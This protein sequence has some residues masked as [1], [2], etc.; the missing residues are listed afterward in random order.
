MSGIDVEHLMIIKD[1]SDQASK[2]LHDV[3][4]N[5]P[6]LALMELGI[7]LLEIWDVRTFESWLKTA[8]H[9]VDH[10]KV[11]DRYLRLRYSI[12]WFQNLKGKLLPNY[13]KVVGICL[14]HCIFD[15]FHTAW[16][17]QILGWQYPGR[18]LSL[19]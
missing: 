10:S 19:Y 17:I 15:L 14:R 3:P 1:F 16:R 8:G 12:E 9:L 7:L 13:Q 4:E 6:E 2:T 11:Q 5:D 18:L